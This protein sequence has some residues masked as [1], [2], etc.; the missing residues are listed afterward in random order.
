[1]TRR[2]LLALALLA[3]AASTARAQ[4]PPLTIDALMRRLAA[5]PARRATF[6]EEKTIAALNAPLRST[7]TLAY[8]R[9]DRL[10]KVTQSPSPET[11]EVAGAQLSITGADGRTH[12]LDL[13]RQPELRALVDTVRATL[14]GDLPALRRSYSVGLEGTEAAWRLT[15][16]PTDPRLRRFVRVVRIDGSGDSPR[17]FDVTEPSGDAQRMIVTPLPAAP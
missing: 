8:V 11:L 6:T 16:V 12:A 1:M 2:A 17:A 10:E 9:P 7:G 14:A 4:S 15:L 5:V 3:A 13:D